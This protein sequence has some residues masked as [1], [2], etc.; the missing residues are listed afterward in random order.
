MHIF[1][2]EQ[3][4]GVMPIG[5]A[6]SGVSLNDFQDSVIPDLPMPKRLRAGG[7]FSAGEASSENCYKIEFLV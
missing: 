4:S 5:L 2:V 7:S 6:Y 3:G 1:Y